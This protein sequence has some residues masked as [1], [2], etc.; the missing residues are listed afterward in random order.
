V[1]TT[2]L[3][4]CVSVCLYD[5]VARVGGVN[6]FLLPSGALD[7]ASSPRFAV[8]AV[9]SLVAR[10]LQLGCSRA[11]LSAKVF[12]GSCVLRAYREAPGEAHLGQR[13]V[14]AARVALARHEIGVVAEDV[15]GYHGRKLVYCTDDGAAFV[16]E[17]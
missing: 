11:R 10:M 13:N 3:G 16:K 6:H 7:E 2:L 1:L 15:G 9:D 17:L 12:G 8:G 14:E 5:E 4:S